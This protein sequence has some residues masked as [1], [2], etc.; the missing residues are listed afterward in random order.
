MGLGR[1]TIVGFIL[2]SDGLGGR[3]DV[4]DGAGTSEKNEEGKERSTWVGS[5]IPVSASRYVHCVYGISDRYE[6]RVCIFQL[7]RNWSN[8]R[9]CW[10][11]EFS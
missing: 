7:V 11:A 10:M 8:E 1:R 9:F 5:G 2:R 4:T 6:L 3:C